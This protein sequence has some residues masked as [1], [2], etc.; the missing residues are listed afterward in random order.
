MEVQPPRWASPWWSMNQRLSQLM[1]ASVLD[2][3][4]LVC[5]PLWATPRGSDA[6]GWAKHE[7]EVFQPSRVIPVWRTFVMERAPA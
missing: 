7:D 3:S 6:I 5:V 4:A 2:L 1:W